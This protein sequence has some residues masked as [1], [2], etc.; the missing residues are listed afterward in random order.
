MLA[1]CILRKMN[2]SS[3]F[4]SL[5]NFVHVTNRPPVLKQC[6]GL[7]DSAGTRVSCPLGQGRVWYV[8][9]NISI[10]V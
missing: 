1:K 3:L 8:H 2:A 9:Y 4:P 6:F 10:H 5:S 7:Q